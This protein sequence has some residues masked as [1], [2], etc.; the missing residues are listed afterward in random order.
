MADKVYNQVEIHRKKTRTTPHPS[1][2][3]KGETKESEYP[4]IGLMVVPTKD[5]RIVERK[6]I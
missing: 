1:L 6:L 5:Y 2:G 4:S 3:K